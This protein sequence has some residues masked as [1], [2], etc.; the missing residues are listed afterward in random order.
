M[1]LN[2]LVFNKIYLLINHFN[3]SNTIEQQIK[4]VQDFFNGYAA[5]FD[6]VLMDIA[7]DA[8]PLNSLLTNILEKVCDCAW[9]MCYHIHKTLR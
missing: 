2:L 4:D 1:I 7:A 5:D 6:G 9:N 8:V 3:M